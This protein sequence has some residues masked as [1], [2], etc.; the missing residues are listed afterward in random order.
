MLDAIRTIFI[1]LDWAIY[2]IV[3]ILLQT[4]VDLSNVEIFAES[5]ISEFASRIYVIL[6]L[7]MLFKIMISF[8]QILIDPDTMND[9]EKGVGNVL[10]RVVF[11]LVLIFLVPSIFDLGRQVQNYVVP[12][13]PK[14]V[15]GVN[16][17]FSTET[18]SETL[19]SVGRTMAWYSFLPFFTYNNESCNQGQLLGLGGGNASNNTNGEIIAT[20]K[21]AISA[22]NDKCPTS[23]DDRG[24][25][26]DYLFPFSTIVGLYLVY[27]LVY[28]AIAIAI[29]AIKLG[30]CEFVAPIPIASY[31]DPKT[32][33]QAFD[34]WVS[35]SIKTYLDLFVRLIVVYF[36]IFV[37]DVVFDADNIAM[38]YAK[39]G[40][41]F[42]RGTM[43]TLFIILG[44]YQFVK[45]APKFVMDMLGL[46][47]GGDIAS[48]FKGAGSLFAASTKGMYDIA[49]SNYVSQRERLASQGKEHPGWRAAGSAVAGMASSWGRSLL[50]AS[51]G[52]TGKDMREATFGKAITARNNRNYR[53]DVVFK[54]EY[55][56]MDYLRDRRREALQ[57]PSSDQFFVDRASKYSEML[58]AG[59]K[60][61]E[62]GNQ[63]KEE[64]IG[65]FLT[66]EKG[67]FRDGHGNLVQKDLTLATM[68]GLADRKTNEKYI[69]PLTGKYKVWDE[70]DHAYW[71]QKV[72]DTEKSLKYEVASDLVNSKDSIAMTNL[73]DIRYVME[74]NRTLFNDKIDGQS[75]E[76]IFLNVFNKRS[77]RTYENIG[78]FY[79]DLKEDSAIDA[80]FLEGYKSAFEALEEK[81][82]LAAKNAAARQQKAKQAQQ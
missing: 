51:Q 61:I 44:L 33:K 25:R 63:K 68:R 37:L 66:G 71:A 73:Q 7:V 64:K 8:I 57:I 58:S 62:Y 11:S 79:N 82:N 2:S 42:K 76:D 75:V 59:K 3:E 9:K 34:N 27:I 22:V 48:M 70:T 26:Y 4:I 21:Q 80:K 45:D 72:S 39:I 38:I 10:K 40:G 67:Y 24:Y 28:V 5:V 41:S 46:K 1:W 13:I 81:A 49:R 6:G 60:L 55:G 52:K 32:S 74:N 20:V 14:V 16:A 31:I 56:R 54:D 50:A 77:G 47:G 19:A 29:R 17:D 12:I 53:K 65:T 69:D 78:Q 36:A 43:I 18:G 23:N 35:T 30:I 15:L